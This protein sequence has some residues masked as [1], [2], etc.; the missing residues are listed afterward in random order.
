VAKKPSPDFSL[1]LRIESDYAKLIGNLIRRFLPDD[2]TPASVLRAFANLINNADV[3]EAMARPI[4]TRMVTMTKAANARSWREA[5]SQASRGREIYEALQHEMETGVGR[6]VHEL[7][8]ENAKLISSIPEAI[9]EEV[10]H[11]I[12]RLQLQGLRPEVVADYLRKRVPQI[13]RSRA[14]LIARTETGKAATA[15]TRARSEDLNINWF[16]WITSKD[17]RVRKSH[18]L[19]EK[20]LVA[21]DD[22]PNPET[23][24]HEGNDHG[25]YG[26]G[27]IWNCRCDALPVTSLDVISWPARY[28]RHGAIGR[29]TRGQF[30]VLS[31]MRVAA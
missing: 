6:R 9:R 7:V 24:A 28:Y 31:G 16:Q 4:A 8:A 18:R 21:W 11:E 12:A 17:G 5:A 1:P 2:V 15:L 23:L 13:T 26:P 29:I 14:A 19:M 25:P 30:A 20:V 10:D 22:L 3:L 27:G